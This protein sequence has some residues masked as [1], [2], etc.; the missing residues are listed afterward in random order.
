[1][2]NFDQI[3]KTKSKYDSF[4]IPALTIRDSNGLGKRVWK[5]EDVTASL[6]PAWLY[7]LPTVAVIL[8]WA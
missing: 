6:H 1:M 3:I 8:F 5:C 4:H 7:S 2:L